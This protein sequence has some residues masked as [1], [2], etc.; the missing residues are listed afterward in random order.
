MNLK[1]VFIA[2]AWVVTTGS[3]MAADQERVAE[4]ANSDRLQEVQTRLS[5]R[6]EKMLVERLKFFE[7]HFGLVVPVRANKKGPACA[8]AGPYGLLATEQPE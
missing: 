6:I 3:A 1:C 8:D 2:L 5:D 4:Q 7:C